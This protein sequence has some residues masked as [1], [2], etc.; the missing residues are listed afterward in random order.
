MPEI[1]LSIQAHHVQLSIVELGNVESLAGS[2]D[3]KDERGSIDFTRNTQVT[4]YGITA[5]ENG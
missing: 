2:E 4:A 1:F 5:F 3:R